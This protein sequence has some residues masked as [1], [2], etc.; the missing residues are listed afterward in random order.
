LIVAG[1][2][3]STTSSADPTDKQSPQ[4]SAQ[5]ALLALQ[6][7]TTTSAVPGAI[8]PEAGP[9]P[10]P[11]RG[12]EILTADAAGREG[13]YALSAAF[14]LAD[15][16]GPPR[17]PEVNASGLDAAKKATDLRLAIDLSATRMRVTLGGHGF[18]LPEDTEIRARSDRYGHVL[19]WPGLGSY[20]PLAPGSLRALFGERR[21][22]VA[23]ISPAGITPRGD[24]ARRI[25]IRTR[26][27]DVST[28]AASG[29]F[30]IGKLEGAG[31]GGILL[32]RLLLDL[33]NAPPAT[34]ICGV[35]DVPVHVEL[36]WT[37]RGSLVFELTG[38]LRRAE[39]PTSTLLVPPH[40]ATFAQAPWPVSGVAPMLSTAE[41]AA[42]RTSD[43]DVAASPGSTGDAL[44]LVNATDELRLLFVDG[45]AAAWAAPGAR[46]E[47]RGLHRGR[48]IAQ[49]RTFFGDS[50]ETAVT[51]AVPGTVQV[52]AVPDAG[53]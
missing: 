19:L 43:V 25:G 47:L 36:R 37:S 53:K 49:W 34:A 26:H 50:I 22:D 46:G 6:P 42:L 24:G 18:V 13:G 32:C 39:F 41:L 14:R 28:R 5:P 23:P 44:V 35:D 31:E 15:L 40:G 48:Y 12:D 21:L 27:V 7:T 29:A 20:R 4:A 45:V 30:E 9:P 1:C 8:S 51:Q 3:S 17:A 38:A 11:F 16:I 33:M 2:P 10:S 52:G